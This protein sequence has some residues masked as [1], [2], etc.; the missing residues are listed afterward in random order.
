MQPRICLSRVERFVQALEQ[1]MPPSYNKQCTKG[2]SCGSTCISKSKKCSKTASG[3]KAS[4]AQ[5][6]AKYVGKL[7]SRNTSRLATGKR[8]GGA[9]TDAP[10]LKKDVQR[11]EQIR[12]IAKNAGWDN[13]LDWRTGQWSDPTG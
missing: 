6:L 12:R 2:W 1:A 11:T 13:K 9:Q 5:S 8:V 3:G 4:Y 7:A 10:S